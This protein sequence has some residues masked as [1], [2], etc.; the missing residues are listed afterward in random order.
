MS[1]V[2]FPPT[3]QNFLDTPM[4]QPMLSYFKLV[5]MTWGRIE[6]FYEDVE[7]KE[8]SEDDE[9]IVTDMWNMEK[10]LRKLVC[11]QNF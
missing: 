5:N 6:L 1:I 4:G 8:L 11:F 7:V 2:F 9:K 3:I 10:E